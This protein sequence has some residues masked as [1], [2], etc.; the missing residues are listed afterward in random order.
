MKILVVMPL[1]LL[2]LITESLCQKDVNIENMSGRT[3]S[4]WLD[5]FGKKKEASAFEGIYTLVT[6][7]YDERRGLKTNERVDKIIVVQINQ[8]HY[9]LLE[10]VNHRFKYVKSTGLGYYVKGERLGDYD[11]M[12][13]DAP[14]YFNFWGTAF[15][16]NET[17]KFNITIFPVDFDVKGAKVPYLST[18]E[19]YGKNI[20]G[21]IIDNNLIYSISIDKNYSEIKILSKEFPLTES[22]NKSSPEWSSNGTGFLIHDSGYIVTNHHVIDSARKLK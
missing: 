14:K 5:Y 9:I 22:N 21:Q 17:D 8:Y 19:K 11:N 4:F 12:S 16:F 1:F 10:S 3:E 6:Q 15:E 7:D 20:V 13:K 18:V 2:S